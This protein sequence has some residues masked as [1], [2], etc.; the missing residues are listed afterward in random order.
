M[1]SS[2]KSS[3]RVKQV[4]W[5]EEGRPVPL[6]RHYRADGL[7]RDVKAIYRFQHRLSEGR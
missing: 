2:A 5:L 6:I 3:R 1:S 7:A 4:L